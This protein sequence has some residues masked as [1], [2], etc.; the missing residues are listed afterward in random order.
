[1]FLGWM[2]QFGDKA[3]ILE[4]ES[5]RSAMRKLIATGGA[6]YGEQADED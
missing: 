2:F 5:L 3:E 4:P 1:V 6:V